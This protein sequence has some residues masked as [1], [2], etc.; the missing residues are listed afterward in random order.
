MEEVRKI[1]RLT[2]LNEAVNSHMEHVSDLVFNEG[3][4]GTRKAI[5]FLRDIRN[6]LRGAETKV[7]VSTK[8]DG[9]PSIFCGIDPTDGKFFVA[10]KG[11]FNKNPKL[12]KSREDIDADLSGELNST[13][14]IL[15]DELKKLGIKTGIYQGD[16]LF[17]DG[18]KKIDTIDGVEYITFHPNTIVYAIPVKSSLAKRINSARVGIAFHTTYSGDSIESLTASFGEKIVG[19]FKQASSV[20][21][22]DATYSNDT[23]KATLTSDESKR[24]DDSLSSIGRLFNKTSATLIND[25][26]RNEELLKLTKIYIN[27]LIKNGNSDLGS[28]KMTLGLYHFIHDRFSKELV[29]KKTDKSRENTEKKREE[30]LVFFKNHSSEQISALFELFIQLESTKKL[31]VGVMNRASKMNHFVK[32]TS[33][34]RVTSPEGF[35]AI[36]V[37]GSAVKFVDRLEFSTLNFSPEIIKGWN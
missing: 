13:F 22:I 21:A 10:K 5:N 19:K 34:F 31:L 15:L 12:Y 4:D 7:K 25:I 30:I 37:D 8:I 35:V 9:S 17:V 23:G 29:S 3:V 6:M 28:K 2:M 24:V 36:N 11:I 32:T 26:K 27:S 14:K 1:L 18:D 33:G 16:L 20:W